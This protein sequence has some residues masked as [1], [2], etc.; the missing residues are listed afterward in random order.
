MD[1]IETTRLLPALG[2]CA[3][4]ALLQLQGEWNGRRIN[5]L[6]WVDY[7]IANDMGEHTQAEDIAVVGLWGEL[8]G[9]LHG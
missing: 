7:E 1:R 4:R 9:D 5:C 6:A 3:E 2:Q 8:G